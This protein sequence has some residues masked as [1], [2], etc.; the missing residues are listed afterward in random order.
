MLSNFQ[1]KRFHRELNSDDEEECN[2]MIWFIA[3]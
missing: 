1:E 2:K 3:A